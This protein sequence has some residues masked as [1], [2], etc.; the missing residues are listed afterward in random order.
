ML[1]KKLSFGKTIK[2]N[3]FHTFLFMG[4]QVLGKLYFF[5][6]GLINQIL[7]NFLFLY[8]SIFLFRLFLNKISS[9]KQANPNI[10]NYNKMYFIKKAF[11]LNF[12]FLRE[13][14]LMASAPD[15]NSL[16]SDQGINKFLVQAGIEPQISYTT[17]R[18]FTS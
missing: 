15:D 1:V 8:A 10:K 13:F 3:K 18:D 6:K 9:R 14:R 4:W 11:P 16:S 7:F 5:E 12:F 2:V 17:I